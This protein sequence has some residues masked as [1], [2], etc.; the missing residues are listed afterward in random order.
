[1]I[2]PLTLKEPRH[3]SF[4]FHLASGL[5]PKNAYHFAGF[6]PN[7]AKARAEELAQDPDIQDRVNHLKSTLPNTTRLR[8]RFAPSLLLMPE[9]QDQMLAW[10]WQ[11]MNGTRK[12]LPL[13]LRAA[14]LFCRLK[15]WH[16]LKPIP[17]EQ[18]AP[19]IPLMEEERHILATFNQHTLTQDLSARP[20]DPSSLIT[21]HAHMAD[22]ALLAC[23]HFPKERPLLHPSPLAKPKNSVAPP[24]PTAPESTPET[25]PQESATSPDE[26]AASPHGETPSPSQP[27]EPQL[28]TPPNPQMGK[29]SSIV[30]G[31]PFSAPP[32]LTAPSLSLLSTTRKQG[33][34]QRLSSSAA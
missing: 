1:M 15:G 19:P 3:E 26:E 18:Q 9:T 34:R 24:A 31:S 30:P 5:E 25:L 8:D 12:V 22:T 29:N 21:Y 7:N 16:L 33:L 14:T 10:L 6:S 11:V 23:V 4:A 27:V 17:A 13:Q 2:P 28:K 20:S 32:P